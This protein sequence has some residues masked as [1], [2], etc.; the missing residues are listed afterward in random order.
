M[1]F[2]EVLIFIF[3]VCIATK[4]SVFTVG[5]AI[6]KFIAQTMLFLLQANLTNFRMLVAVSKDSFL[7]NTSYSYR[8]LFLKCINAAN[9]L[10]GYEY[11]A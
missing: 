11:C 6:I 8:C 7:A 2:F 4:T 10:R 9:I 1:F 5:I 3:T